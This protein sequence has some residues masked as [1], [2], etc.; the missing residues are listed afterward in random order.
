MEDIG[1]FV[2]LAFRSPDV[3]LGTT[4]E[5]AGDELTPLQIADALGRVTNRTIPYVQI[6]MESFRQH[7]EVL[8]R[9]FEWVSDGGHKVDISIVRKLFPGLMDFDTWVE[10][11]GKAKFEAL[12]HTE[13]T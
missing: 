8:A 13:R 4:I 11:Q 1:A 3:Y 6:P 5:I 10:R 9:V 7:N 12:F 2:A